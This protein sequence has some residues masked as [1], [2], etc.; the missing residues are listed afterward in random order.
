M[1]IYIYI[2]AYICK[3]GC[4][5]GG[6]RW[7]CS[8]PLFEEAARVTPVCTLSWPLS[9]RPRADAARATPVCARPPRRGTARVSDTRVVSTRVSG[10]C[11]VSRLWYVRDVR[12]VV[13]SARGAEAVHRRPVSAHFRDLVLEQDPHSRLQMGFSNS[14]DP[15]YSEPIRKVI[16]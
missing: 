3:Y 7:W 12:A 11:V 14:P 16:P 6:T 4:K 5:R 8:W 13:Q 15:T 9:A 1:Y 2:C 10:K